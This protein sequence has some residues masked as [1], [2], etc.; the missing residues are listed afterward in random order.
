MSFYQG[1]LNGGRLVVRESYRVPIESLAYDNRFHMSTKSPSSAPASRQAKKRKPK[2]GA[3]TKK[4]AKRKSTRVRKLDNRKRQKKKTE[5]KYTELNDEQ[6]QYFD[7]LVRV[8]SSHAQV[9]KAIQRKFPLP[10]DRPPYGMSKSTFYRQKERA[11]AHQMY[12]V[13]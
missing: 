2:D 11:V 12:K 1:G 10:E 7:A 13:R 4:R 8:G 5:Q 9:L 3:R 6:Y